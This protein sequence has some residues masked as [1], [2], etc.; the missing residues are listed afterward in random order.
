MHCCKYSVLFPLSSGYLFNL[1]DIVAPY[2]FLIFVAVC[3]WKFVYIFHCQ[4][5]YQSSHV[6]V[7]GLRKIDD[8]TL[9]GLLLTI[10]DYFFRFNSVPANFMH[11]SI[12]F[13]G[14][15]NFDWGPIQ[16]FDRSWKE[17][18]QPVQ[19]W[20]I[21]LLQKLRFFDLK[22]ALLRNNKKI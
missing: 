17:R 11:L 6:L 3:F 18:F 22:L 1:A 20:P 2:F 5:Q 15:R 19:T 7:S 4:K 10:V 8:V 9:Y 12:F 13:V 21:L 14:C 16:K